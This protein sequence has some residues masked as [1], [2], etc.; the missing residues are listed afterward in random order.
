MGY[1]VHVVVT[2]TKPPSEALMTA[3]DHQFGSAT[4]EHGTKTV[5]LSEHVSVPDEA[6][7]IEFV[8]GLVV[9][10]VPP[11]NSEVNTARKLARVCS[12]EADAPLLMSSEACTL[13]TLNSAP[14]LEVS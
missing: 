9:D 8:R 6:D 11:G 3:L 12:R 14:N 5:S 2:L 7:A 1:E 10:A 13:S 4:H